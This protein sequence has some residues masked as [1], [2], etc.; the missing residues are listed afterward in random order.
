MEPRVAPAFAEAAP[1]VR[2][3][4]ATVNVASSVPVCTSS[5]PRIMARAEARRPDGAEM[6]RLAK[7][8]KANPL[9]ILREDR[10]PLNVLC[11][12][13]PHWLPA[14]MWVTMTKCWLV[15]TMPLYHTKSQMSMPGSASDRFIAALADAFGLDDAAPKCAWHVQVCRRGQ[16]RLERMLG[17]N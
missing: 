10:P 6:K 7:T 5:L 17:A 3:V 11:S 9:L 4:Y 12:R 1:I 15:P 13:L 2:E 16:R 14:A 8:T